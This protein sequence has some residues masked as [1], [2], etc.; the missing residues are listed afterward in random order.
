MKKKINFT[1]IIAVTMVAMSVFV[2]GSC[3]AD[4]DN[5]HFEY[6][7]LAKGVMTRG[8]ETP[9]QPKL[10]VISD[11]TTNSYI[12]ELHSDCPEISKGK[13]IAQINTMIY[14]KDN[15]P[16]IN[17]LSYNVDISSCKDVLQVPDSTELNVELFRI[18]NV[19]LIN[20]E[21]PHDRYY[22]Y[23]S[24]INEVGVTY[25]GKLE[26]VIFLAK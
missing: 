3:N 2:L 11:T 16:T 17:L 19:S 5:E 20:D 9:P 7:T 25:S 21:N 12:I 4:D 6:G 26:G 18:S 23:A 1:A 15:I 22:L 14:Y 8:A 10:E 13:Y 24:G